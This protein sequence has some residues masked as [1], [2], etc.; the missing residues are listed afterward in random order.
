[1]SRSPFLW[2]FLSLAAL[3]TFTWFSPAEKILGTNVRIVYLHGAWVW[4]ALLSFLSAGI[5][6][7][8][9]LVLGKDTLN[10]WSRALGRTGMLFW[11]TYLPLSLWAM[12]TNW[13]GLFL[14][15][16]RWRLAIIFSIGGL[17]LQ[18]GIA[19]LD[20]PRWASAANL[21]FLAALLIALQTTENVMHPESPIFDSNAS[22][23]Q[24]YFLGLLLL[25]FLAAWQVARAWF[26]LEKKPAE[27]V[28]TRPDDR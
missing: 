26:L 2:L 12:Q 3:I 20:N 13:N 19:L 21:A 14:A 23:I 9:G 11:I 24:V 7:L 5:V 28:S 16:P 27:I 8:P 25:S 4:T 10:R 1:M 22:R 18:I 17:V 6:G 15:E